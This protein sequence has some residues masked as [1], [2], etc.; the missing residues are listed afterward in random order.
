M[1]R[2]CADHKVLNQANVMGLSKS[3][4][5]AAM[6]SSRCVG[7]VNLDQPET[8]LCKQKRVFKEVNELQ[9]SKGSESLIAIATGMK[10][11]T[12]ISLSE[13]V[14]TQESNLNSYL[15]LHWLCLW[16]TEFTNSSKVEPLHFQNVYENTEYV[17]F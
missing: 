5:L 6:A 16:V 11:D 3:G 9:F 1:D 17:W 12:Y 2:I 15:P 4:T 10:V 7:L 13:S 14:L 8:L